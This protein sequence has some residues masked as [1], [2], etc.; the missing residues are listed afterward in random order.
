MEREAG[1]LFMVWV[2]TMTKSQVINFE[3]NGNR[4]IT[5]IP[6]KSYQM[7]IDSFG[8]VQ[9]RDLETGDYLPVGFK[10]VPS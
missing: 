8:Y 9:F 7:L 6:N 10:E 3:V 4:H 5:F 1:I 2:I